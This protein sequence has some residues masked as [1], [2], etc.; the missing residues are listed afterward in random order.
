MNA[1]AVVHASDR[2]RL[3]DIITSVGLV[4]FRTRIEPMHRGFEIS[5][6]HLHP[7][8]YLV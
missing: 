2:M 3:L 1:R 5:K 6:H 8:K 4:E 7:H